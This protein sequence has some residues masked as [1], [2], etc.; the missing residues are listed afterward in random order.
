MHSTG[1]AYKLKAIS[2]KQWKTTFYPGP[3]HDNAMI[4]CDILCDQ[5]NGF[6][7]LSL[8][9]VRL[10]CL[11]SVFTISVSWFH[12]VPQQICLLLWLMTS[13]PSILILLQRALPIWLFDWLCTDEE[14]EID[15]G[16]NRRVSKM[17]KPGEAEKQASIIISFHYIMCTA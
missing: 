16:I 5:W 3:W 10:Q 11:I 17:E 6:N 2:K 15:N 13:H 4:K 12:Q 9:I 7:S 8:Q 1:N 14:S